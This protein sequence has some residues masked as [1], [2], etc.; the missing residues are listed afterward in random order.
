MIDV[1]K[2]QTESKYLGIKFIKS[3]LIPSIVYN[4]ELVEF[5]YKIG[6]YI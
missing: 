5:V 2:Q 4:K 3:K 1:T 6:G